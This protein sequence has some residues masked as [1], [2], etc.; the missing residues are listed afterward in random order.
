MAD[1]LDY[2]ELAIAD[3]SSANVEFFRMIRQD[4]INQGCAAPCKGSTVHRIEPFRSALIISMRPCFLDV[5]GDEQVSMDLRQW[6]EEKHMLR[7]ALR[8]YC[9]L[10]TKAL[11]LLL[12]KLAFWT[13]RHSLIRTEEP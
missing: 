1:G 13:S 4:A 11:V 7:E 3:G 6:S 5:A 12:N 8:R 9:E 10:D 2:S